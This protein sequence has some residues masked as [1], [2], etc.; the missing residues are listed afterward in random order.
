VNEI[1]LTL[2]RAP[3]LR[4]DLRGMLPTRL[5]ALDDAQIGSMP[6]WHGHE[7]VSVGDC[8]ALSR[9]GAVE[10]PT[11]R[12]AGDLSRCDFL[13]AQLDG[14]LVLAENAGHYAGLQQSGGTLSIVGDAGL[15]LGCEKSGGTIELGG[16]AGDFAAG[17]LPGSMDGMRGGTLIIRGRAGDRLGDRMRR[18]TLVVFGDCGDFA[19][20]RLVAGTIAIA[21]RTGAHVAWGMRRGTLVLLQQRNDWPASFATTGHDV[22]VAW[23]L[24]ARSLAAHGGALADLPQLRPLRLVGDRAVEGIGEVFVAPH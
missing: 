3:A 8:F 20:S 14:G 1:R 17:A 21:G 13:A 23:A 22:S 6:L 16:N 7:R 10:E 11:L 2:R 18:G 5:A 9:G 19:A 12:F 15:A 24:I 4:L